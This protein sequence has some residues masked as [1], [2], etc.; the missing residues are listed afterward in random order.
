[1]L[2]IVLVLGIV[3]VL[4]NR[5]YFQDSDSRHAVVSVSNDVVRVLSESE[6]TG[7]EIYTI[8][9]EKGNAEIEVDGGK[10]R[11]LPMPRELCPKGIC[12]SMGWIKRNGSSIICVPNRLIVQLSADTGGGRIDAVAR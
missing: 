5:I 12:S 11:V 4:S 7:K 9:L 2:I 6:L 1:M 8:P 10:L 3:T